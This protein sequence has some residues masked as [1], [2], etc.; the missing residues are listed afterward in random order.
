[1]PTLNFIVAIALVAFAV[2]LLIARYRS[3][4]R[5]RKSMQNWQRSQERL[6]RSQDQIDLSLDRLD[7]TMATPAAVDEVIALAKA[8]LAELDERDAAA[9]TANNGQVA[10]VCSHCNGVQLHPSQSALRLT[11]TMGAGG[12]PARRS[13]YRHYARRSQRRRSAGIR[14][15]AL[16]RLA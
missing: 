1:M 10:S 7:R 13:K 4:R 15:R 6:Q 3:E 8:K 9:S 16:R 5:L 12:T 2:I 11:M 14:A